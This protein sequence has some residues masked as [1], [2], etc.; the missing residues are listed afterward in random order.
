MH[1]TL[2]DGKYIPDPDYY[3]TALV[4]V[5]DV[6]GRKHRV[7]KAHLEGTDCRRRDLLPCFTPQGRRYVDTPANWGR[8]YL[9]R[10]NIAAGPCCPLPLG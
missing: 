6:Y 7:S 5:T 2:Q 4:V 10:E 8:R 1:E 9:C 3:P